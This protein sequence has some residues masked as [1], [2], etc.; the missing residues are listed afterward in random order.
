MNQTLPRVSLY[1]DGACLN[2][3]GPGGYGVILEMDGK[4]KELSGGFRRTTNNRME[5]MAAIAGLSALNIP[6]S[7]ELY[8]DSQYL[9]SS[10]NEGWAQ[11]WRAKRW[12]KTTKRKVPNHDL[13]KRLLELCEFHQ[14]EFLWVQG[15][16]GHPQNERCDKLAL[17]AALRRD[18]PSDVE[19]EQLE[20][21]QNPPTLF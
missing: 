19:F 16:A 4:R 20:E 13:W 11:K 6:S 9:V 18:L 10:M 15:H 5:L 7:V 17:Q 1:T 2:N 8:S 3:P 12:M 21:E 14:V